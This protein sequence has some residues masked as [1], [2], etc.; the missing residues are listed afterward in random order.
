MVSRIS[1][2]FGFSFVLFNVTWLKAEEK[3]VFFIL[4]RLVLVPH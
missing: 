2:C 1:V 4:I 3:N